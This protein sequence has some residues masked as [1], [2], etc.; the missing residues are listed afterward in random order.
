MK[1]TE[2]SLKK[3]IDRHLPSPSGLELTASRDRLLNALR[4]TPAH[5]LRPRVAEVARPVSWWHP[6]ASMA[7]AAALIVIVASATFQR[8][9]WIAT[10]EAADGSR[11]TIG[12][13]EVLRLDDGDAML[14]LKDGSRVEMRSKA[15]VS[16]VRAADGI[17]IRLLAGDII[18]DA[19]A[20]RGRSLSVRTRDM[21]IAVAG[22]TSL[23]KTVEGGTRVAAIA[24]N[25][26]VHER[27]LETVLQPGEQFSTSPTLD[28][29]PLREEIT[30]S[31]NATSHLAQLDSFMKAMTRTSGA[32][33]PVATLRQGAAE[34]GQA[35]KPEFEE[36]SIRECDP[37]NLPPAVPGSRAG[38]GANS[39]YMTPGRTNALCMTLATLIRNAHGYASVEAE[40]QGI[41]TDP[42]A[43]G[44]WRRP[45][46]DNTV[47]TFDVE[48]GRR[49]RGGPEW[50]RT[51]RY[52]IEAV[53]NG[54]AD[55]AT[56]AGPMLLALLEQ[57]FKLKA[58][59]ET[60]HVP[61]LALVVAAG[62]L[63]I[64]PA[65][66]DSC[67]PAN[68]L[69]GRAARYTIGE[70]TPGRGR[71]GFENGVPQMLLP[72]F[73]ERPT[74][75]EVRRG[76]KPVC[77]QV[78]E[79]NGPNRVLVAGGSTFGA[80]AQVL[81][82]QSE[83]VGP[84]LVYD[85]TGITDTFNWILEFAPKDAPGLSSPSEPTNVPPGPRIFDA[86]QQQLGLRLEPTQA[87]RDVIVIDQ[88]ERPAPN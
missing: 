48:D 57:R 52:T 31:R 17:G 77:G 5:L 41:V 83:L 69:G 82:R 39:F 55:A 23:V 26:R 84:V 51:T 15:E 88:V 61:A 36:A 22:T 70:V 1:S 43:P 6:A 8:G 60:E 42:K 46:G 11:Y 35:A 74:L 65:A 78:L 86:L 24:G 66:P 87:P 44:R 37:D 10:V 85:K 81:G 76:Q 59:T 28:V 7:A 14:T 75:S 30:W 68:Q 54:R 19:V 40:L 21:S 50:V 53:A 27:G 32:L 25:V 72:N 64:K 63:K 34:V 29:R 62:G 71:R 13:N 80:L 56:M 49:V 33:A 2:D 9:D 3:L 12:A 47:A 4:S 73:P 38:G 79:R 20:Q 18:V 67:T 16:L 58:H 45:L